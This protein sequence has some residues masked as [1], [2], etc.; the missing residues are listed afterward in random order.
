MKYTS[1]A[2]RVT[3]RTKTTRPEKSINLS[4]GFALKMGIFARL[5]QATHLLGQ[6]L[7][8]VTVADNGPSGASGDETAQLRRTLMSLVHLADKEAKVRELEFCS[9]SAICYW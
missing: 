4:S 8:S 1:H 3:N 6:A 9:Q 7:K 5:A 2:H